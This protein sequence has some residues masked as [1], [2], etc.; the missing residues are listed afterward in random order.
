[1]LYG[2]KPV[3]LTFDCYGALIQRDEGLLTA[4]KQILERRGRA[5]IDPAAPIRIY[6]KYEHAL[7][8]E[9]PHFRVVS[10]EGLRLA[11]EE[12]KL[13]Y[14]ASDIDILTASN[15][16]MPPLAEVEALGA[17][18][19]GLQALHHLEHRRGHHRRQYKPSQQIF[20]FAVSRGIDGCE[21]KSSRL[22][23][24]SGPTLP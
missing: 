3:W 2:P 18:K 1:M 17:L 23:V 20:D 9:R 13:S 12:L 5:H 11:M 6:D 16:R 24:A 8:A 19:T 10:G 4:V 22:S 21:N 14:S 7:E 15:G